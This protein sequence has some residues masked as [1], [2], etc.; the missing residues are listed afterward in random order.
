M[1]I[2]FLI[3]FNIC[4]LTSFAQFNWEIGGMLGSS[5]YLGD[6]GGK[7]NKV[8]NF[9]PADLVFSATRFS[10]GFF[11]KRQ[12]H[13][14]FF[15]TGMLSY[16]YITGKDSDSPGTWREPRNL[17]F[18]NH[19]GELSIRGEYYIMAAEDVSI[20][21][22]TVSKGFGIYIFAG[23][24][25][26]FNYPLTKY[27]GQTVALQPLATEGPEKKY[28][29]VQAVFPVG[30]G[31]SYSF[32]GS[33]IGS[34]SSRGLRKHRIGLEFNYRF[35]FTDYLDDVSSTYPDKDVMTDPI[36]RDVYWRKWELIPGQENPDTRRY[37]KEGAKRGDPDH[38]DV[39]FTVSITYTYRLF[40]GYHGFTKSKY[41]STIGG[42]SKRYRKNSKFSKRRS[43]K[44]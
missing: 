38:D 28:S 7:E 37:P 22:N 2:A 27:N 41:R 13:H 44:L 10:A 1:R 25:A 26:I 23:A 43:T 24:G 39:Y 12:L 21:R 29:V 4:T 15:V 36:A 6:I 14:R 32:R 40:T 19:I 20:K 42:R 9:G 30:F 5:N 17:S 35:T 34:F 18:F 3:I 8:S 16:I 31:F 33:R 11:L